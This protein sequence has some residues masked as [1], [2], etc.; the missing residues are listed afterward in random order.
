MIKDLSKGDIWVII[1][2]KIRCME[3]MQTAKRAKAELDQSPKNS[4]K[5]FGR[6]GVETMQ[7]VEQPVNQII[8]PGAISMQTLAQILRERLPS[9][10]IKE[11]NPIPSHHLSRLDQLRQQVRVSN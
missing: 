4:I 3:K 10:G 7:I 8:I 1:K 9:N 2:Q 6:R 11:Y 5:S